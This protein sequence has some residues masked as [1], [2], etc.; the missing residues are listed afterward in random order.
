MVTWATEEYFDAIGI[1]LLSGRVFQSEDARSDQLGVIVNRTLA[2]RHWPGENAVGKRLQGASAPPWFEATVVGV[3]GDVRQWGLER[4]VNGEIYFPRPTNPVPEKYI[5]LRG[6][7]DPLSFVPL[8]RKTISGIDSDLAVSSIHAGPDLYAAS[9]EK[10]RFQT[11]LIGL[12]AVVAL[13]LVAAG[14][15]GV[16]SYQVAE[17]THE[18]GIRMALGAETRG[19]VG[20]VLGRGIRLCLLGIGFGLVGAFAVA[21]VTASMLYEVSPTHPLSVAGVGTLLALVAL[22]A[23]LIPALRATSVDPVTALRTE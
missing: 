21:R 19:I 14:I 4:P 16:M 15:Y 6:S 17:T 20:L 23:S 8:L 1:S 18:M 2:E 13:I 10:R 9:A 22:A 11:T 5:V 7:G 12:F 3:V